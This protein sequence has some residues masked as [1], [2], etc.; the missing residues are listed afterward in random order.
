MLKHIVKVVLLDKAR[1]LLSLVVTLIVSI[2]TVYILFARSHIVNSMFA[3]TEDVW[4]G[5]LLLI[6][7][8]IVVELLRAY[9]KVVIANLVKIWKVFLGDKISHNI[10]NMPFHQFHSVDAGEHMTKYTYHLELL[11]AYLF[12]PITG[13]L[14][15]AVLFVA[16]LAFLWLISWKFVVFAIV[17]MAAMFLLSGKFGKRISAGYAQLAALNGEFSGVLKEY[18]DGYDE[19]KNIGMIHL[20]SKE[21]HNSQIKK[22]AQQY[23][24]SKYMAFGEL[25]LQSIEKLFEMLIFAFAIFLVWQNEVTIGAVVSVSSILGVYL[26]A[27]NQLID[28]YIKVLGTK[29]I[30]ASILYSEEK[31]ERMYPEVQERI[32]LTNVDLAY[33]GTKVL[34]HVDLC[35]QKGGKYALVGKSGS[36]KS[37]II[38]L[39]LGRLAPSDGLVTIDE[40]SLPVPTDLNFSKQI[41][42]ISQQSMVFSGTIKYNICLGDSFS[43]E[44]IWSVLDAVCLKDLVSDMKDGL[45]TDVGSRGSS[46][47]GGE[48]QRLV[49][50]RILIRRFPILIL[51]EATAALDETTAKTI[52]SSLLNDPSKTVLMITH[53]LQESVKPYLSQIFEIENKTVTATL[54]D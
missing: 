4:Y 5:I 48:K 37:T 23:Q 1:F 15:A 44:E 51:D 6:V 52:E 39:L 26:N 16:S 12:L 3:K 18:V 2:G 38:N 31:D 47:S 19:L 41:G 35:L 20:F 54:T 8:L 10:E 32:V 13:L 43:D 40:H 45:D 49:L 22:E 33:N 24:I 46:L 14:S 53:H 50:A 30:L 27:G 29:E 34:E 11:S 17:S 28:L 42:Y 9:L 25:T 36:G 21:V 7:L